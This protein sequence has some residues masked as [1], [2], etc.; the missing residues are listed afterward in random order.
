MKGTYPQLSNLN[1]SA[2]KLKNVKVQLLQ[3]CYHLRKATEFRKCGNA[4]PWAERTKL[5]RMLSG[6]L[7][8]QENVKLATECLVA[9]EV[10]PMVDQVK[11]WWI[12]ESFAS[13][14]SVSAFAKRIQSSSE[15][16]EVS[17]EPTGKG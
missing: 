15:S 9:A 14:C 16:I 10:D 17:R 12:L 3:E 4:K 8:Q 13:N 11:T 6:L 5:G 1:E 7:S 2:I